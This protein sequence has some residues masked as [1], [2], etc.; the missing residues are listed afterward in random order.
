MGIMFKERTAMAKEIKFIVLN[1]TKL[2][3]EED[4]RMGDV[5]NL[6]S[7][8]KV[9][10]GYIT[11]LIEEEKNNLLKKRVE[12]AKASWEREKE[13]ELSSQKAS[14]ELQRQEALRKQKEKDDASLEELKRQIS[15]LQ[16]TLSLKENSYQNDLSLIQ[17]DLENQYSLK[18]QQLQ[19]EKQKLTDDHQKEMESQRK[20]KENSFE[21]EKTR[22]EMEHQKEISSLKNEIQMLK[23]SQGKEMELALSKQKNEMSALLDKEKLSFSSYQLQVEQEKAKEAQ[24]YSS[25]LENYDNLR[26]SKASMS[27]KVIGENLESWCNDTYQSYQ[28]LGAFDN[29]TWEK[30]NKVIKEEDETKGSKADY[31]FR[32]F[33]DE[34]KDE[35]KNITSCCLEMKSENPESTNR[36]KNAD[37]YGKLDINRNKKKCEYAILVSELEMKSDNDVPIQRVNG[38]QNMY[39]VR[40]QYMITFL[41]ILKNLSLKYADLIRQRAKED[42]KFLSG[43]AIE[44]E[45]ENL[46]NTYLN[47][48][49]DQMKGK[50]EQ[51]V[52]DADSINAKSLEISNLGKDIIY[53]TIENIKLKIERF[54]LNLNKV[55]KKVDRLS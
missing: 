26:R 27:V 40:P 28:T 16:K 22:L 51:I 55:E 44:E 53:T 4:A 48:P 46:K 37:F 47:K 14:F 49:L 10:N 3:L 33:S 13:A 45:F 19:Q 21:L 32:V 15:E 29:C 5:I 23:D 6:S 31:I 25:L 2:Q 35:K 41:G 36:H 17:K 52:K 39:V 9:D 54:S 11:S 43:K 30:D 7:I 24:K 12:E 18:I 8:Y 42:E 20:E 1:P 34:S 38:Y 50:V